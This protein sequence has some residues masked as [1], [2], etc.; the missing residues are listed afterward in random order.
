MARSHTRKR[1]GPGEQLRKG[2]TRRFTSPIR[3]QG[4]TV[5]K[6]SGKVIRAYPKKISTYVK[7]SCIK[8]RGASG[9]QIG[10][11]RKGEL[12]RFGY[13]YRLPQQQ[14]HQALRQA[15]SQYGALATYRKLN[16][17]AKLSVR[18]APEASKAFAADREWIRSTY[19][20]LKA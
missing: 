10:P 16:A 2:Y 11:L 3:E 13:V 15:V 1:C 8:D 19:G 7:A 6:K 14:R 18:T 9:V 12:K 4:Y 20:P 17:V 5:K